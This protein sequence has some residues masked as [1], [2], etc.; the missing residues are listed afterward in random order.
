MPSWQGSPELNSTRI[1]IRNADGTV[2]IH[3]NRCGYL[4]C[5]MVFQGYHTGVC[6]YCQ[7]GLPRPDVRSP[8]EELLM[9]LYNEMDVP[10]SLENLAKPKKRKFNILEMAINTVRAL[11]FRRKPPLEEQ[12][13]VEY[14]G[15]DQDSSVTIAKRK[16][17]ER[18][19][20]FGKKNKP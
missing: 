13:E 11:A 18:T 14:S 9:E 6:Y 15:A 10:G 20:I 19:P 16:R 17:A 12:E 7:N 5:K 2:N 1:R 4:I 8:Q 3:C